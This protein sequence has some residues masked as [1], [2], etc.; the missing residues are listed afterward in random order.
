M[1]ET[2][3][4]RSLKLALGAYVLVFALK[5]AVYFLTGVLALMWGF[6]QDKQCLHSRVGSSSH[7]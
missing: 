1:K 5:L 6:F 2:G 4:V 7:R 3:D